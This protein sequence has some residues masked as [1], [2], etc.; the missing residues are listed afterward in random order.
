MN[1]LLQDAENKENP[2]LPIIRLI[3]KKNNL[4]TLGDIKKNGY[5]K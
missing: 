4:E 5:L 3:T 1:F 2:L